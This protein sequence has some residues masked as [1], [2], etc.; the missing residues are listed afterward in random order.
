MIENA[1][2]S[3]FQIPSEPPPTMAPAIIAPDG[4]LPTIKQP[5]ETPPPRKRKSLKGGH[6]VT[7]IIPTEIDELARFADWII[8]SGMVRTAIMSIQTSKN[9]RSQRKKPNR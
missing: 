5:T 6:R 9:R 3:E 8:A 4:Y 1:T 7:P 2:M